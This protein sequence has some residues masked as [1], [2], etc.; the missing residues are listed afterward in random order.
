MIESQKIKILDLLLWDEN[1]RLPDK[2]TGQDQAPIVKALLDDEKRSEVRELAKEILKDFDLPQLE[3]LVVLSNDNK[4]TVLEGNRRVVA[5][6][7]LIDPA[8]AGEHRND[9]EKLKSTTPIN[10]PQDIELECLVTADFEEANRYIERK[11]LKNNNEK[12][13]GQL[14]RDNH[15]VRVKKF[16]GDVDKERIKR[17]NIGKLV[18]EISLPDEVKKKVLGPGFITNFYRIVDS[19]PGY[20]YFGL[21]VNDEGEIQYKDKDDLLAKLKVFTY[22]LVKTNPPSGQSWSRAY[23]NN[24]EKRE[25]LKTLDPLRV[26][27][28]DTTIEASKITDVF[29]EKVLNLKDAKGRSISTRTPEKEYPTLI[30]P[31]GKHLLVGEKS[32]KINEIYRELQYVPVKECPHAVSVLLRTLAEITV[33][34]FLDV[35]DEKFTKEGALIAK[36]GK[37]RNELKQKISYIADN[38][39]EGDTRG[40]MIA[41]NEDLF[42]QSL[43]QVV[44]NIG[45]FATEKQVRD[46]WK[47][48]SGVFEFLI[49]GII[50]KE[51]DTNKNP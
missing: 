26:K 5:F 7:C 10:I 2:L 20:E 17:A 15:S 49:R 42:T 24:E 27:E 46:F 3:K 37:P 36:E 48:L 43:N 11:H 40:A 44:H 23:N 12:P 13:W 28:I 51:N 45:Y 1:S 29:G 8:L 33:K 32:K 9:F 4:F 31:T 18:E 35:N 39:A 19:T 38:Y 16:G 21:A 6:Q 47:T 34:R 14:E 30:K 22:D 41:L 50:E 25:Y